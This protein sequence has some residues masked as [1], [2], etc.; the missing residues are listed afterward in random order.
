MPLI[1]FCILLLSGSIVNRSTYL[2][3]ENIEFAEAD[4]VLNKTTQE[5]VTLDLHVNIFPMLANNKSV[6]FW[7]DNENI[8]KI[9]GNGTITS[10]DFGE[11]YVYVRSKENGM[12]TASCKVVVT[13]DRVHKIWAENSI[14][15]IYVDDEP[16]KLDIKYAPTDVEDVSYTISSS[17][18]DIVYA[19]PSGELIAR[20]KGEATITISLTNNPSINHSFLVEAKIP[21]TNISADTSRVE[22]GKKQF[23]F[24]QVVVEP[25]E[26][27]EKIH[28]FSSDDNT[29]TVDEFGNITFL[30]AGEV[31]IWAQ[32]DTLDKKLEKTYKSTF[33]YYT[34]ISFDSNNPSEIDFENFKDGF[35]NL[36]WTAE[37]RD[38]EPDN[39][40]FK[41]SNSKVIK[42]ENNKFKVIGGGI[43]TITLTAKTPDGNTKESSITISVKRTAESIYSAFSNFYYT[44]QSAIN[45]DF[46]LLPAD[47]TEK[48]EYTLSDSSLASIEGDRLIFSSKALQNNYA[49]L[50]LL[51]S[52]PSGL[53]KSL[54]VVYI[55]SNIN[56]IEIDNQSSLNFVMPKT[57]DDVKSFALVHNDSNL[58]D[59][60]FKIQ[61]G[62]ENISQNGCVF[63]LKN[64]GSVS[65]GVY[66]NGQTDPS[67]IIEITITREVEEINNIKF[68]ASWDNGITQTFLGTD[69][70]YST[71]K[72]F[73]FSYELYPQNTTLQ[74]ANAQLVG[75]C[76]TIIDGAVQFSKAGKVKLILSADDIEKQIEIES[77][78]LHPDQETSVSE[79]LTLTKGQTLSI[80][81]LIS[82]KPVNYDTSFI[83]FES[84][85]DA[86]SIDENGN[87]LALCGGEAVINVK[88][89]TAKNI[90]N[91]QI[92]V[93]VYQEPEELRVVGDKYLFTANSQIN[94]ADKFQILPT[95]SNI[96]TDITYLVTNSSI[97]TI[98]NSGVLTFE[99]D[100]ICTITATLG[101]R[102]F[103]QISVAYV[104]NSK[105]L[106]DNSNYKVYSGTTVVIQP[107]ALALS[108]ANFDQEFVLNNSVSKIEN[109]IFITIN[110]DTEVW[111]GGESYNVDC[112]EP[113][114][115]ITLNPADDKDVDQT[116]SG[117]IT[118]LK[119]LEMSGNIVG[120]SAEYLNC[121]YAVDNSQIASISNNGILTFAS[122]G[123]V[124]V[125]Y[126]ATYKS[127]IIGAETIRVSASFVLESTFGYI[128][129]VEPKTQSTIEYKIDD[130]LAQNILNI[131]DLIT[132]YPSQIEID[133]TNII[134]QSTNVQVATINGL[135]IEFAKGGAVGI[136][137]KYNSPTGFIGGTT[138]QFD[139]K[140]NA[141][142]I[143]VNGIQIVDQQTI[144]IGKS[145]SFIN[146]VA[147]PSDANVNCN[148]EWSI[149]SNNDVAQ[150]D[151]NKIRFT[152]VDSPITIKFTL[153]E[154]PVKEYFVYLKT[155][156]ITYEVDVENPEYVVP[157]NEPF[158]FVSSQP[159]QDLQVS[160]GSQ[161]TQ[162]SN[163][164]SEVYI[165]NQSNV[166]TVD[167]SYNGQTKTV[168]LISTTNLNQ[169]SDVKLGDINSN[170]E[171]EIILAQQNSLSL[172]TAS[173]CIDV[174]YDIPVAFDKF[175]KQIS[176][177]IRTSD[178]QIATV[179]N[180][181]K[182]QIEF[183]EQGV[184]TIF[185][186]IDYQDAY[187]SR[188]ISFA[189]DVQS[190]YNNITQFAISKTSYSFVYDNLSEQEKTVNLLATISRVAP[191]YGEVNFLNMVSKNTAVIQIVDSM[192][193][194]VGSGNAE[195]QIT[196]GNSSKTI[197]FVV[198]KMIDK[199]NF[200][201][202]DNI[203]SQ[204]VTNSNSYNLNY[205]FTAQ[206]SNYKE[207]L[208]NVAFSLTD[209]AT[210][211][212]NIVSLPEIDKKYEVT[213]NATD[214][215]A[216][217]KLIIIRVSESTQIINIDKN[218]SMVVVQKGISNI[219]NYRFGEQ[220]VEISQLDDNVIWDNSSIQTFKGIVG[221]TGAI[222]L[223]NNQ[224][225]SYVVKEDVQSINFK[226]GALED[227]CITALGDG[228]DGKAINLAQVYGAYIMPQTARDENGAYQI[229][230]SVRNA[231]KRISSPIAYIQDGS[232]YFTSA[233]TVTI[234]FSAGDKQLTRTL[235]STLGY[236]SS[237]NFNESA[238][239]I[240]EYSANEYEM[241]SDLY[242][243]YP[244][245][246]YK[247][248]ITL[249]SNNVEVFD[250]ENNNKLI[251]TG[252][253]EAILSLTYLLS[254]ES[255]ATITK[256]VYIKNR[257]KDIKFFD[258]QDQ[259]SYM[260]KN[261]A[262]NSQMVLAYQIISNGT[263]S[264]YNI[265][266]DSSNQDVATI[267]Q[268]G[269]IT[270]INSGETIITVKVQEKLNENNP[271]TQ[272]V[273]DA[274][275]QLKLVYRENYNVYKVKD[276][277]TLTIEYDDEKP[278]IIYPVANTDLMDFDFSLADTGVIDISELGEIT[279]YSGG[280]AIVYVEANATEWQKQIDIYVHRKAQ[281]S[282]NIDEI[283]KDSS[284]IYDIYTS[285][286]Q[287]NLNSIVAL[288][289]Q[290]TLV[291]KTIE[292]TSSNLD[293]AYIDAQ[294]LKFNKKGYA[295]ITINILYNGEIETS[296][297]FT[298]YSS[299]NTVES[300]SLSCD[301]PLVG[302]MYE[303]YTTDEPLNFAVDNIKPKDY[304]GS[305]QDVHFT[306]TAPESFE[307]SCIDWK[308]FILTPT[309]AGVGR[310]TIRYNGAESTVYKSI[311]IKVNQLSTS[312]D[313]QLNNQT[314]TTFTT[315]DN[316]IELTALVG[317]EDATNKNVD[318]AISRGATMQLVDSNNPNRVKIVFNSYQVVTIT[319]TAKDGASQTA[320]NI[321]YK[322]I[323]GFNVSTT[324]SANA[325]G[326]SAKV[327]F[328]EN[329]D[330]QV[331][332]L[333]WNQTQITFKIEIITAGS[334][335]GFKKFSNFTVSSQNGSSTAIDS[336]GYFTISTVAITTSPI[337]ED[338]IIIEYSE[339]Y[340]GTLTIK[341]Y[342][343]GLQSI[344]FG[345]HNATKDLECGLQQMR[346]YGNQSYYNS[347]IQD[348]YRMNV[349]I[350]NNNT[351]VSLNGADKPNFVGQVVWSCSD[352]SVAIKSV[353]NGY[354]DINFKNI[355][356]KNTFEDIYNFDGQI[357]D[358]TKGV[359][360]VYASNKAGRVLCSYMFVIVDGVNIFDQE[361]YLNAGNNIVLQKSF[362]HNDQS[363]QISSGKYVMLE[364]YTAKNTI[365]GNGHLMNFAHRNLDTS[366]ASY[367]DFENI[368]VAIKN[369]VNLRIQGSNFDSTYNSYNIELVTTEKIAYCEMYYM[370][371][372]VEISGGT[373]SVRKSLLR[374]F[375]SSGII[376]SSDGTKNLY[377]EDIIM[378]DVGQRAIEL[379]KNATAYIKG[380]LDVYNFQN[381]DNVQDILG[382]LGKIDFT[383]QASRI[384]MNM[385]RDN[386]LIVNFNGKEWVNMVGISTKGT[387]LKMYYYNYSTGQYEYKE[388]GNHDSA[389]G[390]KRM[391]RNMGVTSITAWSYEAGHEYLT[392]E[393]EF[394]ADGSLNS[395][396]LI[397]TTSKISRLKESGNQ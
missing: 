385:A 374:S 70:I 367:Q 78:Y 54:T 360:T 205:I 194:I 159:L 185:I 282:L 202:N 297:S 15:T 7:S 392:I 57:G 172:T 80:F 262:K 82:K 133:Q 89:S 165:I 267:N 104:N 337:Y 280:N 55:N 96:K 72:N 306:S 304:S 315:F 171:R 383:G 284:S 67:K 8:V 216:S 64:N 34:D 329:K 231:E 191:L 335:S 358:L 28:Y 239:L 138:L 255:S 175:G 229:E 181:N 298:V 224:E 312:V 75:D 173:T 208:T 14:S 32:A 243:V 68:V 69:N 71:S 225:I 381:K 79:N 167:I 177:S 100:G 37:P 237:V 331:A 11:T 320:V 351:E 300:F 63:T 250:V 263:L 336:E 93:V 160:F 397:S 327:V 228:N 363:Q 366:E 371:R 313:I 50:K 347:A 39:L 230:Y 279:K 120:A 319:A 272:N 51:A 16:Y 345:D 273:F 103:A 128:S 144:D 350:K 143:Y 184:V 5:D 178:S 209:N 77:T 389:S 233:G 111:F 275:S 393:N 81:D 102:V 357:S 46:K 338:T 88:I 182:N 223:N 148:I 49:K 101:N 83:T 196:W 119:L 269:I 384:I 3:V 235:T 62:E 356:T 253:G 183:K 365:Y 142:A 158:T 219:F 334:S 188:H 390:L 252:G 26:A 349:N 265:V 364:A 323:E 289:S 287:L 87:I 10:G 113:I 21:L 137:V 44:T 187:G 56:K 215:T 162:I 286:T 179:S 270:F 369:A 91:K 152:Q 264:N 140:R 131:K 330:D 149:F 170:G 333:D 127:D 321:E 176:Y 206:D 303:I 115:Q 248:N 246:A 17:N 370:Y 4:V 305:T 124:K 65:V 281:I 13:S 60:D 164:S 391:S 36:N 362:G 207:T 41:S 43:A 73:Q 153:G 66:L 245:N 268:R 105:I 293:V 361:G 84:V 203:I 240:F 368:Q 348:Y 375:K 22:S 257:A 141:S 326:S 354:V 112:V 352:P 339:L 343:D 130:T 161:F 146:P 136:D 302:E 214:G 157:M 256:N 2:Y 213:I 296:R 86:I 163:V 199:I 23:K 145:T 195:V 118:G 186:N 174:I 40:E 311:Q 155:S 47:C 283:Y 307:I 19:S 290:D 85:G 238:N 274:V 217:A 212:N 310:F 94:L 147:Y 379:Q 376:G 132:V 95:T 236:A 211:S 249:T 27:N 139:V 309:K 378:F 254:S 20:K 190:T 251:F 110:A 97:A 197:N 346:V 292:Y 387:D 294:S 9:D 29:A 99:K 53:T 386:N 222:L 76:A 24:P 192:A 277:D 324:Q 193:Q 388:D 299:Y 150:Q 90:I 151:G 342:R 33:G 92:S 271:D 12:K 30:K 382:T 35:L 353:G 107:S 285:K 322:D 135:C 125:T 210:I 189:F 373:V 123:R 114:E 1:I 106:R 259:V 121:S 227:N 276:N 318:W 317:P 380:F 241:P 234:T 340:Q 316:A 200:V 341:L 242:S 220:V 221:S 154:N 314:I 261:N 344:N 74:L 42:I 18:E 45:L 328:E 168:K 61:S 396:Y 325:T 38:A 166:G 301:S 117:N 244:Q 98:S 201:E 359:V 332:Y 288:S 260:V 52:T 355:S 134:A 6:E 377:L 291:N 156:I 395:E 372:S 129:R 59:I 48:L 25:L 58:T 394:K 109:D 31:V 278:Y 218:S 126:F 266:F 232:L 258:G 308:N 180:T 226:D 198:D 108:N 295:T 122:A 116:L 169:I 204:V 247:S